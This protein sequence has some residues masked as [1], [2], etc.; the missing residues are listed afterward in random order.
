M[1][2]RFGIALAKITAG[3][4]QGDQS[5]LVREQGELMFHVVNPMHVVARP[6]HPERW[7]LIAA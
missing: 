3:P 7:I 1:C 4:R 2:G 6:A 5:F